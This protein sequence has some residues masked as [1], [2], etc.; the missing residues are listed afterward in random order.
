MTYV[1]LGTCVVAVSGDLTLVNLLLNQLCPDVSQPLCTPTPLSGEGTS[2]Y[3][4]MYDCSCDTTHCHIDGNCCLDALDNLPTTEE[5]YNI[6]KNMTCELPQLRPRSEVNNQG[7]L[8]V[9]LI[10]HCPA[11]TSAH[12]VQLCTQPNITENIVSLVPVSDVY[13]LLTYGN[14]HCAEC[15]NVSKFNTEYWT[16][17]LDCPTLDDQLSVFGLDTIAHSVSQ[18]EQC[19]LIYTSP[20]IPDLRLRTCQEVIS[21]CN[22]TGQWRIYNALIESA[23]LAF[24]SVFD[25]TYS[26][27]FCY[28]CNSAFISENTIMELCQPSNKGDIEVFSFSALLRL[29][30]AQRSRQDSRGGANVSKLY[31]PV[32]VSM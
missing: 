20:S 2:T 17:R 12:L 27:V 21:T 8:P 6:Q 18:T 26:N 15:N 4:S 13:S 32:T 19:N 14:I 1:L 7:Y 3:K 16:V 30:N 31:N 5:I 24:S 10:R 29:P 25:S 28:M 11:N 9:R 23:C 22:E